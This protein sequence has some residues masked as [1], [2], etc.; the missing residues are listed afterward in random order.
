M[1]R[2]AS[3]LLLLSGCDSGSQTDEASSATP[4]PAA[5]AG[6]SAPAGAEETARFQQRI[7]QSLAPILIDAESARYANLRAGAA[8]SVCGNVDSKQGDGNYS[9]PRP[10]VITPEGVAVISTASRV[11]FDDPLDPFSDFYI[12][13][14]AS[15]DELRRL[16]P[17]IAGSLNTPVE[18][19]SQPPDF[20]EA[21]PA[22]AIDIAPPEP[23]PAEQRPAPGATSDG[24]WGQTARP[25]ASAPAAP[26]A[27]EDSFADA[28][29]RK[30]EDSK[31][32]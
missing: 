29:L 3:L 8:G 15:P 20:A 26:S 31:A 30:S 25:G 14:C 5:A 1:K 17:E 18:A 13:W 16:G 11:V 32:K 12:R 21:L 2:L 4:T 9:G 28:V 10:F 7:Q 6:I 23:P 22:E 19:G 24:R 27:N